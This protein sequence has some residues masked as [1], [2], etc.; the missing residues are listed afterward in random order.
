MQV[1]Q[2]NGYFYLSHTF[3]KAGKPTHREA[4]LGTEIP[5]NI[6]QRREAFLRRILNEE[7]FVKLGIIKKR[8]RQ[9][10]GKYPESIKKKILLDFSIDFTYNTN[11]IEGSTITRE[12]TEDIIKNKISPNK[13]LSD[14]LE[15]V[16]H[17]EVF[18]KALNEKNRLTERVI[19]NWHQGLFRETKP[20]I[21]G[22]VR[23][24]L[25]RVG[26][27]RAP[28]WQDIP[29]LLKGFF[30]WYSKNGKTMHP[31]ELAARAHYR[32]GKIH[33]FGDG[34]GRVGRLIISYILKKGR[35]PLPIIDYKKRKSYY[36]ALKKTEN[37]FVNYFI[38]RYLSRHKE[39]LQ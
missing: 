26:D 24:Y 10:W 28:D 38:K 4:Y 16:S 31:V 2:R 18:L 1:V 32:F 13:P 6:E 25:V 22:K 17:S 14:V 36:H 7:A 8:F 15:T 34:N 39:F 23:D 33:P 9:Q 11:A 19:L 29:T 21:A 27:Y 35:Y 20:D 30:S 12:E 37:D 3:R 5:D